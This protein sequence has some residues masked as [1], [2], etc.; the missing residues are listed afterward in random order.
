M[1]DES[2]LV[3]YCGLYCGA[4]SFRV[5]F[6]ENDRRHVQAM[7]AKYDEYKGAALEPCAGCRREGSSCGH[8]IKECA[9]GRGLAHCGECDEFPCEH[10]RRFSHDGIPHHAGT[11]RNL[12]RLREIGA[13]EWAEEQRRH[14][15]CECGTLRSWYV[16]SCLRCGRRQDSPPGH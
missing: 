5:A 1:A 11:N 14:W 10:C 7:P 15:T 9:R 13:A 12:E 3:A 2:G 6:L 8:G 16:D 4:C